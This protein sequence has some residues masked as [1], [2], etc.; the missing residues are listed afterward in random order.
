[1]TRNLQPSALITGASK[2]LGLALARGLAADGW[3]LIIDARNS[4]ALSAAAAQLPSTVAVRGDVKDAA[5]REQLRAAVGERLDLLVNNASELGSSPLPPLASYPLD[6]LRT[7]YET[8]VF[9]PL[10]LTQLLLP[11]LRAAGGAV[12]NISSDA[13]VEAYPGWGG[14]GSAKAALDQVSAVLAAEEAEIR[15][16][17]VDPGD[18]RTDMHQAAFPGEDISDRPLPETVVP[19]LLRLVE[20]RPPSGRYR[21]AEFAATEVA[22]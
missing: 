19:A 10:A 5:H 6:A 17:A 12:I 22:R 4:T 15:C 9:A 1:M 3:R 16:Y 20:L 21:A 8:N 13:A 7:V 2:G 11:Q 14:Y 18:L